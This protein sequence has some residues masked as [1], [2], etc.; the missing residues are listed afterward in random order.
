MNDVKSKQEIALIKQQLNTLHFSMI[1]AIGNAKLSMSLE[2]RNMY[3][4]RAHRLA[5]EYKAL[6]TK[7]EV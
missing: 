6:V 7:L 4:E 1:H 2:L 3:K 5:D